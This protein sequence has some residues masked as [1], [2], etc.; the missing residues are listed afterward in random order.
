M[1]IDAPVFLYQ[2]LAFTGNDDD[3][4][5]GENKT[6][7]LL[8][9]FCY[10][11]IKLIQQNVQPIFVFDG[12][13]RATIFESDSCPR[14]FKYTLLLPNYLVALSSLVF[15]IQSLVS[16]FRGG[17]SPNF[18]SSSFECRARTSLELFKNGLRAY[19]EPN[20]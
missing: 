4:D 19:S 6:K 10:R 1:A 9:N 11:V 2:V 14:N 12:K 18:S 16:R 13:V 7:A 17:T 5:N 15:T 20:D 8:K 3:D